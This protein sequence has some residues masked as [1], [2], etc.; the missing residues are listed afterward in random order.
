[1]ESYR[2]MFEINSIKAYIEVGPHIFYCHDLVADSWTL[3]VCCLLTFSNL[4]LW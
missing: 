2:E 4:M 1:M 3:S